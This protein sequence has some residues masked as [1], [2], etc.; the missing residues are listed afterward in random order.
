[1]GVHVRQVNPKL[2]RAPF[3]GAFRALCPYQTPRHFC[4]DGG[5]YP[6]S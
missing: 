1:M 3:L 6:L 5:K 2:S 4:D